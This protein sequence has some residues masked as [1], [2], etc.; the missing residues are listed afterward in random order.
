MHHIAGRT[1]LIGVAAGMTLAACG[2]GIGS[3]GAAT[4]DART[5]STLNFM[6][7]EFPGTRELANKS[8]GMLV[9]PVVTEVGLGLGLGRE[10]DEHLLVERAVE[11]V[12]EVHA[13]DFPG[14]GVRSARSLDDR[15]RLADGGGD[16]R[17]TLD[18]RVP[19][20]YTQLPLPT[21]YFV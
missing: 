11:V 3:N 1:A 10:S 18:L 4:I 17:P 9:M 6:Y 8:A 19:V 20:S 2:N 5:A 13:R 16:G 21:I 7:D 12:V 15:H 14:L